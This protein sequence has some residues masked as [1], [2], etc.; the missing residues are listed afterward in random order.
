[1]TR[2]AK[3]FFGVQ[4]LFDISLDL[5]EGEVLGLVG[6]NGAGKSTM[7][8]VIGGVLQPD[9]GEMRLFGEKYAPQ[10]PLVYGS[11][12]LIYPSGAQ[13]FLQHEC[14]GEYLYRRLPQR[15]SSVLLIK[16]K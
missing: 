7:M 15:A 8:N 5:R 16:R 12:Y 4:V 1:M 14:R 9:S 13:S 11:R 2:Y 3:S 10:S 6:E